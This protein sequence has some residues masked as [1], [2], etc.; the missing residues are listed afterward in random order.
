MTCPSTS[1]PQ[2]EDLQTQNP[3]PT[4]E[5]ENPPVPPSPPNEQ[6]QE[7]QSLSQSQIK[8]LENP[9]P[10][11]Q[12]NLEQQSNSS[13]PQEQPNHEDPSQVLDQENQEIQDH[14]EEEQQ[15]SGMSL[16]PHPLK[17]DPPIT[18]LQCTISDV[19][20]TSPTNAY[21]RANKRKKGKG[22][23]KKQQAIEK[24]LQTLLE[25]LKPI[26]FKP[27][28][29]LDF[30][31][32]EKLLKDLGLWD[33]V[34]I[35]FDRTIRVD[36]IAQLIAT[37]DPKLRGSYVNEFKIAV[38]RADLA[39]AFKLPVKKEKGVNVL[40]G[41][42]LDLEAVSEDSI[43]FLED[44]VSNWVL[45]HED[46]WIMPCEVLNW[47]R[48]IKDGHFEKVDW[49]GLVWF[50]V[51]KE[52]TQGEQLVDCYYAS[53]LQYL[54]KSQREEVMKEEPKVEV[55]LDVEVKEEEGGGTDGDVKMGASNEFEVQEKDNVVLE[56]PN[57][58]LTLGQEVIEKEQVKDEEMMDAEESKEEEEEHGWLLDGK[59]TAGQHI[60]RHCDLGENLVMDSLEERKEEGK[61]ED[62]GKED[63]EEEEEE[64]EEV[65]GEEDTED[66]FN[67]AP[68]DDSLEGDG[69]TGNLLQGMEAT[70]IAFS[71]EGQVHDQS[72]GQFLASRDETH[73]I[74]GGPSSFGNGGKRELVH[75]HDMLHHSLH[76]S[77]KRLRTDS[78]WDPKPSDFG[79]C[80]Q[81]M[82]KLMVK[83]RLMYEAK[84]QACEESNMNQQILLDEL[85]K[86][87]SVIAHLQ[88]T[89]YEELQKRDGEILRL[90][91]ELYVMGNILDGFR[92][93]LKATDKAFAEYRQRC[94]IPEEP[95]YKDVGPG[96]LML[97]IAEIEKQRLKH[98]E[99]ERLN[100][101][102]L[103][104][105]AKEAE[106][107]YVREFEVYHSKV[108]M[109][110]T[111]LMG[112]ENHVKL[113]KELSADSRVS[114]MLKCN[115]KD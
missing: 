73:M 74:S 79:M 63:E 4:Q 58:E 81:Q 13:F 97:S 41:V 14:L 20:M 11:N 95:L 55:D 68:N 96:G 21:R 37:Y 87:D 113:L 93:A 105:K 66:G 39:R 3:S 98:E 51:E 57:I 112:L 90:E 5:E 111:R 100:R 89:S 52:L 23:I 34:H 78:L 75:E 6:V 19:P 45:L 36:L 80:M 7:P 62:E 38:N 103:E 88:K 71:L 99:E 35:E 76:G 44:F 109:L 33:F 61:E 86:R 18:D 54:M 83:S 1:R 40:E 26:P 59:N 53:H 49:A 85:H 31:K 67:I 50:M 47:T 72:S 32:H 27:S 114:E 106:E 10:Q 12:E 60:L 108:D 15:Q 48:V 2:D 101:V 94:Q 64:E 17:I 42:D 29:T 69:L 28:K 16:C 8:T 84:E 30:S 102:M 70:H 43:K 25:N 110:N 56:E 92:K 82:E 22:S 65:G 104:Q 115:P 24:K 91:R 107:G 46:T 77:N 9:D